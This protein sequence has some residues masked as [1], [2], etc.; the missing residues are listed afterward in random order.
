MSFMKKDET[1]HL[2]EKEL[3]EYFYKESA[4]PET[5][6]RHINECDYCN[7]EYLKLKEEMALIS[8]N[9]KKGFWEAQRQGIISE[10]KRIQGVKRPRP[11]WVRWW[12]PVFVTVV[13]SFLIIGIYTHLQ[14]NPMNY[15]QMDI[16]EEFLLE[17]VAELV[18]QPLTSTLDFLAFKEQEE[19]LL[20]DF[21]F[22]KLDLFGY[23]VELDNTNN[24]EENEEV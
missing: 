12:R 3:I 21:T 6:D 14:H 7:K 23:W 16:E 2:N 24:F 9:F 5:I 22:E 20:Y 17:R 19:E 10:V 13:L 15:T 18:A 4:S 11:L 8:R 1:K